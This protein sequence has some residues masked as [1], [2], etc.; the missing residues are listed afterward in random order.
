M[1]FLPFY[2]FTSLLF[3]YLCTLYDSLYCREAECGEGYCPHHRGKQL[4][5]RL[6][7]RKRI[8]SDMDVRTPVYTE[9]TARLHADVEGVESNLVAHDS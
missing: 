5:R 1:H 4:T 3:L 7:G 6:Y 2:L 9:G 8:P